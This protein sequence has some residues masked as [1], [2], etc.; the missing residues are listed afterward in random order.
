ML[1]ASGVEGMWA[2]RAL[3]AQRSSGVRLCGVNGSWCKSIGGA[4]GFLV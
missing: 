2:K 4:K 1:R 3:L